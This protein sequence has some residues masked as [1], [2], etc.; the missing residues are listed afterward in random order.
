MVGENSGE[1]AECTG[2]KFAHSPVHS[3]CLLVRGAIGS[4][5]A[6][7]RAIRITDRMPSVALLLR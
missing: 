6:C 1:A 4:P 3:E 2:S 5:C 7:Q